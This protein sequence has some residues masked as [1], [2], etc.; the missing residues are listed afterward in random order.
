MG[1]ISEVIP[2]PKGAV[3]DQGIELLGNQ[4]QVIFTTYTKH[5]LSQDGYVFW[6]AS[7]VSQPF[8]GSL[9]RITDKVQDEDRTIAVNRII[10]TA[11]EK[12]TQFNAIN[13]S[14]LLVGAW[15][16]DGETLKVVFG[17]TSSIYKESDIYH[18]TG[19]AV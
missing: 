5:V 13:S 8:I 3:L 19:D 4:T 6:V 11:E 2:T 15:D 14:T 12:I 1:L 9:H 10:F 18:Y 16:S 7:A 17:A